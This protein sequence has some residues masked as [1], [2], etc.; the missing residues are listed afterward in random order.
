[1]CMI[2]KSALKIYRTFKQEIAR[3]RIYDNTRGS[4]L[5]F[6]ARTGVLRTKTYRAKYEGVDTVRSLRQSLRKKTPVPKSQVKVIG[7]TTLPDNIREVLELGPKFAVEPKKSAPE[8]LGMVRQVSKQVPDAESDRCVSEESAEEKDVKN[9]H[10]RPATENSTSGTKHVCLRGDSWLVQ[11]RKRQSPS[12]VPNVP[13]IPDVRKCDLPSAY[14]ARHLIAGADNATV[15]TVCALDGDKFTFDK[16]VLR[17]SN[18]NK[19][20]ATAFVQAT[21]IKTLDITD[22]EIADELLRDIDFMIPCRGFGKTG[23]FG[24]NSK[25]KQKTFHDRTFR[26]SCRGVAPMPE[27]ACPQCKHLRRLLLSRESYRRRKGKN[28]AQSQKLSFR[29]KLQTAQANRSRLSVLQAKSLINQ[30]K[31]KNAQND[32]AAFE[33]AVK[34]LLIKQQ[35][36]VKACFAAA[37][38]IACA[39]RICGRWRHL[40]ILATIAEP[41]VSRSSPAEQQSWSHVVWLWTLLRLVFAVSFERYVPRKMT[42]CFT[43]HAVTMPRQ[44]QTHC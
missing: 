36:L 12:T 42:V 31:E 32:S 6:E 37:K 26:P 23:E 9:I 41:V 5:L 28:V 7:N 43:V 38:R 34:A 14:W 3:E 33:E 13:A 19:L 18:E 20:Q 16:Y 29:L 15:F 1:M 39:W 30:M 27:K 40:P 2:K 25:Y 17:T 4:S 8:L 44:R 21:K 10:L 11:H 24:V 35:Q 22:I